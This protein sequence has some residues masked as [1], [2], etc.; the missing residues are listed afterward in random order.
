MFNNKYA[1]LGNSV[2]KVQDIYNFYKYLV[3]FRIKYEIN[4]MNHA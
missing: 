3:P 1:V 2:K 4:T